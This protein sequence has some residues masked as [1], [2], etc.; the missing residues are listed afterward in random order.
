[1]HSFLSMSLVEA[2]RRKARPLRFK[3]SQSLES[4]RHR[5]NHA[6]VCSTT[7]RLGKT[8]KPFTASERL[9]TST[10]TRAMTLLYYTKG[11]RW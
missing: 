11:A 3:H 2:T 7:H 5:L 4:L 1:M 6:K 9:T 10:F 8:T